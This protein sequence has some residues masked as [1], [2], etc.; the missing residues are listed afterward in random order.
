MKTT[1]EYLDDYFDKY[2]DLKKNNDLWRLRVAPEEFLKEVER[3]RVYGKEERKNKYLNDFH[4]KSTQDN[5]I[6]ILLMDKMTR[7]E[8]K[9]QC[10]RLSAAA[11]L[12][13]A[14]EAP[15]VHQ[16]LQKIQT[17]LKFTDV[18]NIYKW[19][20]RKQITVGMLSLEVFEEFKKTRQFELL[21]KKLKNL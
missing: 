4:I 11:N 12:Q 3:I 8:M 20:F 16:R 9:E 17:P 6:S 10:D 18:V 5:M 7:E 1:E 14:E 21:L 2:N 13:F 15:E 19:L